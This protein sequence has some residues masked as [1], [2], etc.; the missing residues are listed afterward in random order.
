MLLGKS[1]FTLDRM[2][3]SLQGVFMTKPSRD[4]VS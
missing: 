1:N 2:H 3:A 4:P